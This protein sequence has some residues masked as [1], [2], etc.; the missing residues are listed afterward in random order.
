[1]AVRT[2]AVAALPGQASLESIL[3]AGRL[4]KRCGERW[5]TP[6]PRVYFNLLEV[7]K[8]TTNA[9]ITEDTRVKTIQ[10]PKASRLLPLGTRTTPNRPNPN[11]VR[12]NVAPPARAPANGAKNGFRRITV[13]F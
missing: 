5:K 3:L 6:R 1:M 8:A 7:A 9:K 12:T 4:G 11:K 10:V 2:L 13:I